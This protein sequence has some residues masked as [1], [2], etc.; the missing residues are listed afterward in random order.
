MR[1][2]NSRPDP[3]FYVLQR[4]GVVEFDLYHPDVIKEYNFNSN[5]WDHWKIP[6]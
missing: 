5:F 4:Y 1:I 2:A 3:V 6:R